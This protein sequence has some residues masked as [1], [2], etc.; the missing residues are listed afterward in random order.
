M[1]EVITRP[2]RPTSPADLHRLA[3]LAHQ[4]GLRLTQERETVW[5]CTSA[6]TPDAP[7][8]VTGLSCD[9]RGFAE[10]QRC[11]HLAL[12]LDHLG[13]LP[14]IEAAAPRSPLDDPPARVQC[15]NCSGGGVI[16]VRDGERTGWPHPA[17][18]ACQGA[19]ELPAVPL[20][21]PLTALAA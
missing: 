1:E 15:G 13:W 10:H 6:S 21:D 3:A 8:Y 18:P 2:P 12:L 16:Y 11:T 14:A 9:C 19:G 4:R 7:H 5:F 20:P 17:C